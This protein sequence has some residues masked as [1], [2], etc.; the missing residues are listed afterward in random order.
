MIIIV[1][2]IAPVLTEER[3]ISNEWENSETA[4]WRSQVGLAVKTPLAA[5]KIIFTSL[6]FTHFL[7]SNA[8]MEVNPSPLAARPKHFLLALWNVTAKRTQLI[9]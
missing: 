7:F 9:K 5:R 3:I 1:H 2:F 8:I 6:C 4:Q